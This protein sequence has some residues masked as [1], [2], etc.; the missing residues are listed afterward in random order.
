M[1]ERKN[2]GMTYGRVKS[3]E[4][5]PKVFQVEDQLHCSKGQLLS[6]PLIQQETSRTILVLF[7]VLITIVVV[8]VLVFVVAVTAT[9]KVWILLAGSQSR[10]IVGRIDENIIFVGNRQRALSTSDVFI[11]GVALIWTSK[12]FQLCLPSVWQLFDI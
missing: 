8:V 4:I 5:G 10:L 7:H 3:L 9:L 12:V 1:E 6:R 2:E 11:A